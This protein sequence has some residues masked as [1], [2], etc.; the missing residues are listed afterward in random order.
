MNRSHTWTDY[1]ERLSRVTVYIH[2]H[3]AEELDLNQLSRGSG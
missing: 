3:L 2:D 1:Q